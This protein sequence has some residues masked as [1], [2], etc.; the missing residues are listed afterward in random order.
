MEQLKVTHP[1]NIFPEFY[2]NETLS[3]LE[4]GVNPVQ[5]LMVYFVR[6]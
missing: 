1:I 4:R 3:F 5:K 6:K 2:R